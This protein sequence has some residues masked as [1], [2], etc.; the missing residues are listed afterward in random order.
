MKIALT[1]ASGLVGRH[2]ARAVRDAGHQ[3]LP[4]E[5]WRLGQPADLGGADALIHAAFSH[6]PGRY[7]GG[8][9]DDPEGFRRANLDGS[10]RLFE[11]A[12]AQG[13]A[14]V[15][16]L[17]SRAVY[18]GWP[19]G[20]PLPDGTPARPAS[21]Y[22]QVKAGAEAALAALDA[23]GFATASL[24]ATGVYGPGPGHKW[25]ALFQDYLSGRPVAP[26]RG[27]ELHGDDLAQAALMLLAQGERGTFNVSDLLLDRRAL[28]AEVA[29]L[30]GCTHPLPAA[31]ETPVSEMGCAR[32]H[33]MG[34]QPR[35][36][37]GLRAA[38][39]GMLAAM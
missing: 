9:G 10:A 21:L 36:I 13:V 15:V 26:R 27:T 22:G 19:A 33:A 18:D 32:L 28:L 11:Q 35:G 12:R 38:L 8:E 14:H 31:D 5:G 7:R 17:S 1:G 39:P 30:T 24:R 16:F 6:V 20:T 4:L 34:W 37:A 29:A 2:L 25:A 23:P 3:L